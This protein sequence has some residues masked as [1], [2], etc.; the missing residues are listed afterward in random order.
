MITEELIVNRQFGIPIRTRIYR[1]AGIF[2][3]GIGILWGVTNLP[4]AVEY[5]IEPLS[6]IMAGF[7]TGVLKLFGEPVTRVG[8]VINSPF[9]SLEIT[10]A[11]TGI[12][13]IV[14]LSAGIF[15]WSSTGR[16][17]W[18]G[19]SIG[20]LMLMSVNILRIISIYYSAL[21]IPDWVPFIHSVFWEGIMVLLVP[22][23][24][25]YWVHRNE[26]QPLGLSLH[27]NLIKK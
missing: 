23:F 7:I 15:A 21:I 22:V 4:W 27:Y 3:A 25:M 17:R 24:W 12:Y 8:M 26:R 16:E 13:Q 11:C 20:V 5:L 10:P 14:V 2:I 19:V 18:R 1:T 9:A 6:K